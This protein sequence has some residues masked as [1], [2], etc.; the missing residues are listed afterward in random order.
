M[1]HDGEKHRVV[2]GGYHSGPATK[3]GLYEQQ[4]NLAGEYKFIRSVI[5]Y[6]FTN[7]GDFYI[8]KC[9]NAGDKSGF[10]AYSIVLEVLVDLWFDVI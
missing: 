10:Y 2:V 6:L 7:W 5:Y 9:F 1:V 3:K 8:K 4:F